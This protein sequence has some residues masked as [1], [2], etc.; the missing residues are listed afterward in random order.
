MFAERVVAKKTTAAAEVGRG[1]RLNSKQIPHLC[2][3]VHPAKATSAL[4]AGVQSAAPTMVAKRRNR[5]FN[6]L[7]GAGYSSLISLAIVKE[8]TH[9]SLSGPHALSFA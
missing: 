3:A 5:Y 2:L 7:F 6:L 4:Q 1:R 9:K 8:Q